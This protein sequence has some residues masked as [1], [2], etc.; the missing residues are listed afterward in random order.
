MRLSR[1]ERALIGIASLVGVAAAGAG[2]GAEE[3]PAPGQVLLFVDTD[4]PLP[5]PPG[6]AA[7]PDEPAALFDTARVD[8]ITP[9]GQCAECSHEFAVDRERIAAGASLGIVPRPGTAGYFARVRLFR[10]AL[11]Q[12]NEPRRDS[13]ID[14]TVAL[15]EVVDGEIEEVTV[16]LLTDAVGAPIGLYEPPAPAEK[17]RPIGSRVG[18][19]PGAQRVPCSGEPA[20]NEVCVPGGA[21]WMGNPSLPTVKLTAAADRQRLVVVSPFF[22]DKAEVTVGRFRDSGLA[23]PYDPLQNNPEDDFDLW[24]TYTATPGDGEDLPVNCISWGKARAYCQSA[25]KDLATQKDL[26]TEAQY[27]YAAGALRS[28]DFVWGRD[29]PS[30]ADAVFGRGGHEEL[31]G[32]DSPC[33]PAIGPGGALP[34]GSGAR[35]MLELPTGTVLDLAGNVTEHALDV[36][37]AQDE[38][39][40]NVP[41][42]YDPVCQQPGSVAARAT[43]GGSWLDSAGALLAAGRYPFEE[44]EMSMVVGFR[45]ARPAR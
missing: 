5:A 36:W 16:R 3:L 30:C 6:Q 25:D 29:Y 41:L 1:P 38:P 8:V 28:S 35:D 42:L 31:A 32:F 37:N 44:G 19:W 34:V 21:Y 14:V 24:C 7:D 20:Q 22:L 13:T 40:W 4:A 23:G 27:E 17:G 39:C 26:V 45:C 18:S 9:E 12:E 2:C 11:L 15:P 10:A 33:M 43:R